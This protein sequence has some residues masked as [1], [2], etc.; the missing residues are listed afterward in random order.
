M[1]KRLPDGVNP[2]TSQCRVG[3]SL[4]R[5]PD[6]RSYNPVRLQQLCT[7]VMLHA[8]MHMCVLQGALRAGP[9]TPG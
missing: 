7:W 3:L 9:C 2:P 6:P 8:A 1:G 4:K 5:G